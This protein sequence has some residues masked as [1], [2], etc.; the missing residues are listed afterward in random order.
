MKERF[1]FSLYFLPQLL[2]QRALKP[3]G[4]LINGYKSLRLMGK[5]LPD[6]LW[7]QLAPVFLLY[8]ALI[9]RKVFHKTSCIVADC[10][11][12]MFYPIWMKL[13]GTIRLLNSCD[14]VLVHNDRIKEKALALGVSED[15]LH[16]LETR[17]ALIDCGSVMR[18]VEKLSYSPPWILMPCSF[19][20]DEPLREVLDAAR[21]M[22]EIHLI[23]TGDPARA[24]GVHDLS[25]IP[26][27]VVLP[28]F[29][30][31]REYNDHL[32]QA[33]AVMGLTTQDDV[34]LSV[35]NEAV[36]AEKALV[37]SYTK[38]I[39]KMF[40]KGAIYVDTFDPESIAAGCRKAL[41]DHESLV[42][43][44]RLLQHEKI[45]RWEK[46]AENAA[47]I[48]RRIVSENRNGHKQQSH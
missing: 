33:H 11:N 39:R 15:R 42:D 10:H 40:Y 23:I 13:P 32:C 3:I 14:L 9:Y 45:Q 12:G 18:K 36:V 24:K 29:L 47:M 30:S 2:K 22:P 34:Q 26:D 37:I 38:L 5:T 44:V 46:Q 27:N 28:G 21:L 1:G 7:I 41:R 35:A 43:D 17:P 20:W 6:V 25:Q 4:Y 48:I 8:T 31:R 19:D 16:V